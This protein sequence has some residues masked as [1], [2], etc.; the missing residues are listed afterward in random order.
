MPILKWIKAS[1]ACPSL[2]NEVLDPWK[3]LA[4]PPMGPRELR[5]LGRRHNLAAED[6]FRRQLLRIHASCK[7]ATNRHLAIGLVQMPASENRAYLG[8]L[9]KLTGCSRQAARTGSPN[10]PAETPSRLTK[11]GLLRQS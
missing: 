3:C 4:R 5:L 8:L 11:Y 10:P 6:A 9:G 1:A 7:C 2:W